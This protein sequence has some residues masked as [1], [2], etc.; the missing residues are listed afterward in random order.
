M[1]GVRGGGLWDTISITAL[2]NTQ[3]AHPHTK[4]IMILNS[5]GQ[6]PE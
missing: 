4:S 5:L 3:G 2:R 1:P 6:S